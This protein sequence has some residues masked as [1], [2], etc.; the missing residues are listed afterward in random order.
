MTASD[1]WQHGVKHVTQ[2]EPAELWNLGIEG[3]QRIPADR[4][5]GGGLARYTL[6]DSIEDATA[7]RN[8][9]FH[10][11]QVHS[12]VRWKFYYF[13]NVFCDLSFAPAPEGKKRVVVEL[14]VMNKSIGKRW[15]KSVPAGKD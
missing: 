12:Y 14:F 11:D 10:R 4:V 7:Y 6:T 3:A 1:P 15:L 13:E 8:F 5:S 2:L 9:E